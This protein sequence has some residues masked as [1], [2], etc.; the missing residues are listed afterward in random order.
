MDLAVYIMVNKATL[1]VSASFW[2]CLWYFQSILENRL[3]NIVHG[4][5]GR[6]CHICWNH[7]VRDLFLQVSTSFS[8]EVFSDRLGQKELLL[9]PTV[10]GSMTRRHCVEHDDEGIVDF[11]LLVVLSESSSGGHVG[12]HSDQLTHR[13]RYRRPRGYFAVSIFFALGCSVWNPVLLV[14][15]GLLILV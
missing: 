6:W 9:G 1:H 5:N 15:L 13:N 3:E 7:G 2:S 14:L 8:F 12:L 4:S 10:L 11:Q